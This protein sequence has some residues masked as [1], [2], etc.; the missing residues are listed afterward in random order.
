LKNEKLDIDRYWQ[1]QT[2]VITEALA[3]SDRASSFHAY[4]CLISQWQHT[5]ESTPIESWNTQKPMLQLCSAKIKMSIGQLAL[6]AH[7]LQYS[8]DAYMSYNSRHSTVS[9]TARLMLI[10]PLQQPHFN[11]VCVS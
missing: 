6:F 10:F 9:V 1:N 11:L 8:A 4:A 5:F 2:P 3:H 7:S